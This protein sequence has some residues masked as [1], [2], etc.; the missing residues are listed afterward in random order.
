MKEQ[1]IK[2]LFFN[3]FHPKKKDFFQEIVEQRLV[4]IKE[5][6]QD[7]FRIKGNLSSIFEDEMVYAIIKSYNLALTDIHAYIE[8]VAILL[9]G[10]VLACWTEYEIY[11]IVKRNERIQQ[12]HDEMHA[13]FEHRMSGDDYEK[14]EIVMDTSLDRRCFYIDDLKI[15]LLLS[16][17][18]VYANLIQFV[19]GKKWYEMLSKLELSRQGTHFIYYK[20]SPL[21]PYGRLI[22]SALILSYKQRDHWLALAPF[23]Q[24]DRWDLLTNHEKVKECIENSS[25][26][27]DVSQFYKGN[28]CVKCFDEGLI[29]AI[30]NK[31]EIAEIIRFT[32]HAS[33]RRDF[34]QLFHKAYKELMSSMYEVLGIKMSFWVSEEFPLYSIMNTINR[35]VK[36]SVSL[37][38]AS[39]QILAS[40]K[41]LT[42]KGIVLNEQIANGLTKLSD[43]DILKEIQI[44]KRFLS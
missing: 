17:A 38:I 14:G 13:P 16:D 23:F 18:I 26:E 41:T 34:F 40:S 39:S 22:S 15:P 1:L 32:I 24:T 35:K 42:H 8:D 31:N 27:L 5:V 2:I 6:F 10:D 21:L 7:N 4:Q 28:G 19:K 30:K 3:S 36:A 33:S 12:K 37:S 11:L 43:T 44:T 20:S 29:R 25:L 9:Y